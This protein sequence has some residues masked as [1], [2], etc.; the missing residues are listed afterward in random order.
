MVG[1]R[2]SYHGKAAHAAVAPFEGINALNA[3]IQLFNG[4]DALRQHLRQDVRIH[5][6]I[7]DG[8]KAPNVVPDYAAANF[9]LRS[10][11]RS[12]LKEVVK[13]V[14]RVAEGAALITGARLEVVPLYPFYEEIR[15][16]Q[17]L[18]RL[19]RAHAEA[20]DLLVES[21]PPRGGMQ[22][23]TDF[24]NVSQ[25]VPS[26]SL[27]YATS[28]GLVAFHTPAMTQVSASP[29]AQERTLSAAQ[30]LASTAADLLSNADLVAEARA[31]FAARSA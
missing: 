27:S 2:Y 6:I 18:A 30:I 4:I 26:F 31:D 21:P 11:D 24:G 20:A 5:G 1:F 10:R 29:L 9:M 13:K 22:A 14:A 28:E 15:P 25:V 19:V 3:V 12:Y 7:T 8:G 23:S 17:A 16:N